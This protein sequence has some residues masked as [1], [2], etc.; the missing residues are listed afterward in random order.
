MAVQ[1]VSQAADAPAILPKLGIAAVITSPLIYLLDMDIEVM[2]TPDGRNVR[3]TVRENDVDES[4]ERPPLQAAEIIVSG[5]R[6][7]K[8][9]IATTDEEG[10]AGIPVSVEHSDSEL[11]VTVHHDKFNPRHLRVD[12]ENVVLDL[13]SLLYGRAV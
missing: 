1:D 7:E 8:L 3:V 4:G 5:P 11:V 13:R 6:G 12:G 2:R 9:G 10:L